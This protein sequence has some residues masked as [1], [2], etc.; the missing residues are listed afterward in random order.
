MKLVEL[1]V[2]QFYEHNYCDS[3][4]DKW[5]IWDDDWRWE[6]EIMQQI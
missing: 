5:S 2:E 6:E 1:N 4:A 3:R